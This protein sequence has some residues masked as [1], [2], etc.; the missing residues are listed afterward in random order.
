MKNKAIV[1]IM[2]A[3]LFLS[4]VTSFG[5]ASQM[6]LELS[7]LVELADTIV[8]GEVVTAFPFVPVQNEPTETQA[9][10]K[11]EEVLLSPDGVDAYIDIIYPGGYIPD[12]KFSL[13]VTDAP[14]LNVGE[15]YFLFLAGEGADN[16]HLV[17]PQG[18]IRL[19]KGMVSYEN[20][21]EED[22]RNLLYFY[23]QE[24]DWE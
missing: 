9:E 16:Y 24:Y 1:G 12:Y 11:V 10:V 14:H 15:R 18:A 20:M 13:A 6:K 19:E 21:L 23:V 8:I 17:S 3:V 5:V 4:T 22:F 2:T 7:Q